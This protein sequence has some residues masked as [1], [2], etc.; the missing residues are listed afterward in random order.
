MKSLLDKIAIVRL[1]EETQ[2]SS[3]DCGDD[4][5]NDFL[6]N[7]ANNYLTSMLAVTYLIKFETEIA[8][9]FCLSN[10]SLTRTTVLTAEEKSL[11]NK[12]G[13]KIPNSKRRKTYPAV[14]IGRLAVNQKFSGLGLGTQIIL[15][16]REMYISE[17]HHAGCRFVTVDAYRSA[18][19]FYERN[20]FR[21][22]TTKDIDDETRT[23]YFDLKAV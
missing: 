9:Y 14:K 15:S 22:L 21:Y 17:Q 12:V 3:F 6:K 11:W 10:D 18:L 20:D 5:L 4:D 23:M 8:A 1:E 16:V 13:R 2:I 19:S 7:D